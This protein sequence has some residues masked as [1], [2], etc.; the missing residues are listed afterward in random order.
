M[1]D[2]LP[3]ISLS[4]APSFWSSAL[5]TEFQAVLSSWQTRGWISN[6]FPD[7]EAV[8]PIGLTIDPKVG[9]DLCAALVSEAQA[10]DLDLVISQRS[11]LARVLGFPKTRVVLTSSSYIGAADVRFVADSVSEAGAQ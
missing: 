2:L 8:A 10:P 3:A 5:G 7:D 1:R 4:F 11:L 9:A 6:R